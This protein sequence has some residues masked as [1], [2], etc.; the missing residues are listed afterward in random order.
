LAQATRDDPNRLLD[1]VLAALGETDFETADT[2][3]RLVLDAAVDDVEI[4][5][6]VEAARRTTGIRELRTALN[7]LSTTLRGHGIGMSRPVVASLAARVLRPGA[8]SASDSL[9][10]GLLGEWDELETRLDLEV[11]PRSLAYAL[12]ESAELERAITT[13]TAPEGDVRAWRYSQ[14][15][16][17]LWPRG[18]DARAAS[19]AAYS[20]FARLPRPERL[21]VLA[22]IADPRQ[23]IDISADGWRLA[24]DRVLIEDGECLLVGT[25]EQLRSAAIAL[26][27]VPTDLRYLHLHPRVVSMTREQRRYAAAVR[28]EEAGP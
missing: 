4:A 15:Y 22:V 7:A 8:T 26:A 9:L 6:L 17:L 25:S 11:D 23:R 1:L 19:L 10:R 20:P 24:A 2:E 18:G 28:L 14:L 3:L 21:L 27:L 13:E 16:G 12:S 5:E